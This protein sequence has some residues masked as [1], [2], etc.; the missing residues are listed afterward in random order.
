MT[1]ATTMRRV[2]RSAKRGSRLSLGPVIRRWWRSARLA[3]AEGDYFGQPF[4]PRPWQVPLVDEMYE[5]TSDGDRRYERVLLGFPKGQG[6]TE[7]GAIVAVTELCGPVQFAGWNEDG[8]P[9]GQ[10][11]VSPDIPVAAASFEQADHLF[12]AA[13]SIVRGSLLA[14]FC[15]VYDTEIL[16]KGKPGRLYRVAAAAGTNDGGKPTFWVADE[17]H[18]WTGNKERVHLVLSNNRRK[19]KGAWELAITTAGWDAQSLLGR[20]YAHGK[21]ILAGEVNDSKFLFR[22]HEAAAEWDLRDPAQLEAAVRQANPAVGD[23]LP[24]DSLLTAYVQMP[25]FEF[26]RYH[27]NQFVSAPERWLPIGSWE[28]RA[29]TRVVPDGTELMLGFDGSFAGDSTA[30]VGCTIA[31]RHLFVLN[32]WE[33]PTGAGPDWRVDILDVEAVVRAACGKYRVLRIGCDPYRWQRSLAVLAEV[34]LPVIEWPSHQAAHMVPACQ[35]FYEAVVNEQ[36]TQDGG[37]A[38]ARHVANCIVKIDSRGPR[39]SKDHKDSERHID[40]AVAAVI[41]HDLVIRNEKRASVYET[42]GPVSVG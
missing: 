7:L 14:N 30:L 35:S 32:A 19:R 16:L 9:R 5:L 27:L 6:K 25:E 26:R 23:F 20:M 38:F 8:S 28:G 22:W 21:R 15:E 10:A 39:I 31:D 1:V 37:E 34:G 12:A 41:A 2:R 3:H 18:E 13:R 24:L 11:R 36:L 4:T 29:S 33:K 17:L 40:I 42:R